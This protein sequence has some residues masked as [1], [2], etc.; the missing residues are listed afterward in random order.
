M[1]VDQAQEDA[2]VGTSSTG[3]GKILYIGNLK[4][5]TNHKWLRDY[6]RKETKDFLRLLVLQPAAKRTKYALAFFSSHSAAAEAVGVLKDAP[7]GPHDTP[8]VVKF[9]TVTRKSDQAV[10][11]QRKHGEPQKRS[12]QGKDT[13]QEIGASKMS[14]VAYVTP[15]SVENSEAAKNTAKGA[16][17]QIDVDRA[18]NVI[19]RRLSKNEMIL[20]RA[21]EKSSREIDNRRCLRSKYKVNVSSKL[22]YSRQNQDSTDKIDTSTISLSDG[23]LQ[24]FPALQR[25]QNS[26]HETPLYLDQTCLA[27]SCDDEQYSFDRPS[28][29][30]HITGTNGVDEENLSEF[31]DRALAGH[32]I[33]QCDYKNG[34]ALLQLSHVIYAEHAYRVL[35]GK[36]LSR[37]GAPIQVTYVQSWESLDEDD[38]DITDTLSQASEVESVRSES[39]SSNPDH[40]YDQIEDKKTLRIS[41]RDIK[42]RNYDFKQLMRAYDIPFDKIQ[43][44][45]SQNDT[46]AV[47]S[48]NSHTEAVDA[49]RKLQG[50]IMG[51]PAEVI[52]TEVIGIAMRKNGR[53]NR[54]RNKRRNKQRQGKVPN[55]DGNILPDGL[56]DA[57]GMTKRETQ[58]FTYNLSKGDA[59]PQSLA[60]DRYALQHADGEQMSVSVD[61]EEISDE[62]GQDWEQ[63]DDEQHPN[64]NDDDD[65]YDDDDDDD[66]DDDETFEYDQSSINKKFTSVLV[67]NIDRD[68]AEY[69][70]R[71]FLLE[72]E[73]DAR[74][75]EFFH[76]SSGDR[77]NYAVVQFEYP[78]EASE[79]LKILKEEMGAYG[80][81]LI[82]TF[83]ENTPKRSRG[84]GVTS[85]G[86]REGRGKGGVRAQVGRDE[87]RKNSKINAKHNHSGNQPTPKRN[88]AKLEQSSKH[89]ESKKSGNHPV[90]NIDTKE[91]DS[92]LSSN[93]VI[94]DDLPK[95]INESDIAEVVWKYPKLR[96]GFINSKLIDT[97]AIL[98]FDT[99]V[100]AL[101]AV[102]ELHFDRVKGHIL[103]A[104]LAVHNPDLDKLMLRKQREA[105]I[106]HIEETK[107]N[108]YEE[109]E[110][111]VNDL[112][113]E[114]ASTDDDVLRQTL[115]HKL[116]ESQGFH[117]E[118]KQTSAN[119]SEQ[120]D[121]LTLDESQDKDNQTSLMQLANLSRKLE[122][123]GRR[124]KNPLPIYGSRTQIVE[125]VTDEETKACVIQAETG[126]GKSTQVPQY[127]ME[128]I[129]H[130]NISVPSGGVK[131]IICT[132][133]RRVAAI[134]LAQRIAEEYGCD[135]GQEVGFIAGNQKKVSEQ[136]LATF[137]TDRA[138]LS[139][140]LSDPKYL[141]KY[142]YVIIDEAHERSVDTDILIAMLK[143]EQTNRHI[144]IVIMSATIDVDLFST[145]FHG[146]PVITIPGRTFPV[147]VEWCGGGTEGQGTS[148]DNYVSRA[149]QKS[150]DIHVNEDTQGDILV[151]LTSQN[152][153][154]RACNDLKRKLGI[155]EEDSEGVDIL[156]L[157]GKLQ[158][159]DQFK[160]F[161]KTPHG[162]R[163]IVFS[164]NIAETS[165]TIP[166]VKYVIDSGMVKELQYD[167]K[168]NMSLL[169]VTNV[170]QASAEQRRGRAGRTGPGK[171]Y[172][173]YSHEEYE[174]MEQTMKPEILRVHLGMAVTQLLQMGV[175]EI[176]KFQFVESPERGAIEQAIKSLLL[177]G[178][179]TDNGSTLTELGYQMAQLPLEPRLAKMILEGAKHGVLE[180]AIAMAALIS[181]PGNV[182]YQGG[183][184]AERKVADQ[185][186]LRF[187]VEDGDVITLLGIFKEWQGVKGDRARNKWCKD[188]SL[189]AKTLRIV[190]E[191][192]D[193]LKLTIRRSKV[194]ENL[195]T[196][197]P[198]VDT[199]Q[200]LK[201]EL[202]TG[203]V[204]LTATSAE[205]TDHM[206]KS[207]SPVET[208]AEETAKS[209]ATPDISDEANHVVRTSTNSANQN[210]ML[211]K[212]LM[213]AYFENLSVFNGHVRAGYTVA[214]Q[215]KTAV[216]HPSSALAALNSRP[217]WV[218]YGELRR[219]TKD[220]LCVVTPV[221]I[222]WIHEVAPAEFSQHVDLEK[223]KS[224]VMTEMRVESI[225]TAVMRN[226]S[227]KRFE[228]VR[229]M[230]DEI[231]SRAGVPCIIEANVNRGTL[232][233]FIATHSKPM[234]KEIVEK[235]LEDIKSESER[236]RIEVPIGTY[237]SIRHIVKSGGETD[238]ILMAEDDFISVEWSGVSDDMHEEVL[239]QGLEEQGIYKEDIVQI[240]KY[241]RHWAVAKQG[242]W[243]K[244]TFV[245]PEKAQE[246]VECSSVIDPF[247]EIKVE[248]ILPDMRQR[249]LATGVQRSASINT[250]INVTWYTGRSKGIAFVDCADVE[251]ATDVIEAVN[252]TRL[253]GRCIRCARGRKNP[254]S[255]FV[256][257]LDLG[258]IP[259]ELEEHIRDNTMAEIYKPFIPRVKSMNVIPDA[260]YKK[261]LRRLFR[262]VCD[263][264]EVNV[265]Q[266]RGLK[267]KAF[268]SLEPNLGQARRQELEELMDIDYCISDDNGP[269]SMKQIIT[270][271]LYCSQEVFRTVK[272]ELQRKATQ[273][274]ECEVEF[275]D[276]KRTP[277]DKRIRIHGESYGE[278][279]CYVFGG[280]NSRVIAKIK[281]QND[282]A[283]GKEH[284]F[285]QSF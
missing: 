137:M 201:E 274:D 91:A 11:D 223:L 56:S 157:H 30:L 66:D 46:E 20:Q 35:S 237:G 61:G 3:D 55:D 120:I 158:P 210:E 156:P 51:D 261:R 65:D 202:M 118:F 130:Q 145:Y 92:V 113:V 198:A 222:N 76:S 233:A 41:V 89:F 4:Q 99:E 24:K 18:A 97:K 98:E 133:P 214:S 48:L 54:R 232:V 254:R 93:N 239:R 67:R 38:D 59:E 283:R 243:G 235:S 258:V 132:Q 175:K 22:E 81:N 53:R 68:I 262:Q 107:N 10:K 141:D 114:I 167:T 151:F 279:S 272:N 276:T 82:V 9:K 180:D 121:S 248:P 270:C 200:T 204:Q 109:V 212:I 17:H 242:K 26:H 119:I 87:G 126:S 166:G 43:V 128:Y 57:I 88:V 259:E 142:R 228:G 47:I 247:G 153:I 44:N 21:K 7:L 206:I 104:R 196:H 213:S 116:D 207:A 197:K 69:Q 221:D 8:V 60:R 14:N 187:C 106:A 255:V 73:I 129:H 218:I 194:M 146:C 123:E 127:L 103:K 169:K 152:E 285:D 268:V 173:L 184:E 78:E 282:S 131:G 16:T 79:A 277:P 150:Y 138:L 275:E 122:R 33:V 111:K 273:S 161:K 1:E 71:E 29:F 49:E 42:L 95:S 117:E 144:T 192:V 195:R 263:N 31:F 162:R 94:I 170:T 181:A 63:N 164:T 191:N 96:S 266:E 271:D 267:R 177:L 265:L 241:P 249:A 58:T 220:F 227:R 5:N 186:K 171:C 176:E 244:V 190:Q 83:A 62:G 159:Q 102:A 75:L 139:Q 40:S 224:C 149:V 12:D 135:V 6:L 147:D 193:E 238:L 257:Q 136:T 168:K 64:T 84:K 172:R 217:E 236:E 253:R 215:L 260:T 240:F 264:V 208:T 225:G 36:H 90:A 182:Y 101:E 45:H 148:S 229:N 110:E 124:L 34:Q 280:K 205:L 188:N 28:C 252:G 209:K 183:S 178:A 19:S 77:G 105:L 108:I 199:E 143:K 219:T 85:R 179:V 155:T 50:A 269:F 39:I 165:V 52:K 32:T 250:R 174:E 189:N 100:A 284:V 125:K 226:L 203:D 234:A 115:Q 245:S 70:I 278:V 211:R 15:K 27:K 163:K 74:D 23:V 154:D 13:E 2:S 86:V 216:F 80:D 185:L 72:Q 231:T 256:S 112:A 230:E 160:V 140:C 25:F 251:D 37:S 281:L 134:T 246:A